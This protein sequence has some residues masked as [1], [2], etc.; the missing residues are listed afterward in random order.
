[1]TLALLGPEAVFGEGGGEDQADDGH[2]LEQDVHGRAGGV[3]ERVADGVADDGGLV[4]L[5][6]LAAVGAGFDVLLG[7][8]PRAAGVGHEDGQREA[9]DQGT[10]KEAAEGIDADEADDR[11][12]QRRPGNRA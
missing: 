4:G 9:G 6:A 5:G 11:A 12:A 7:V 2:D 8:V 3:L 1:M 10:G